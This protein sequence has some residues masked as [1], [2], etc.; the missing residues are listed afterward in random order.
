MYA[1]IE[2]KRLCNNGRHKKKGKNRKRIIYL[3][4]KEKAKLKGKE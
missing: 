4:R 2:R 1:A 3:V